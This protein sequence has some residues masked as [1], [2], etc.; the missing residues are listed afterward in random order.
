MCKIKGN[1]MKNLIPYKVIVNNLLFRT[2]FKYRS[3]MI[4]IIFNNKDGFKIT[5]KEKIA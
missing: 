3:I 5:L 2:M 1:N 4:G